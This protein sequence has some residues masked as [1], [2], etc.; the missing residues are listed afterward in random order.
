MG[1]RK[2]ALTREIWIERGD[3][4]EE[5]P[6]KFFRLKPGG[7]V[8]LRNAFIVQCTDVIKNEQGEVVGTSLHV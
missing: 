1:T 2:V 4:M 6:R 3:F 5:P 7:E 8:R